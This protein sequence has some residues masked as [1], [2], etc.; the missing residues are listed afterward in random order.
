L[1]PRYLLVETFKLGDLLM[2]STVALAIRR[3]QPDAEML[4]LGPPGGSALPVWE[5][6]GV[7]VLE[8]A[9]PWQQ[10][11]WERAPLRTLQALG[12]LRGRLGS[13]VAGATGLDP[14]GD[15]RHRTLLTALGVRRVVGYRSSAP[16]SARWRGEL[17]GH[18]L[19]A[20][21][22]FLDQAVPAL[23]LRAPLTLAWPWR[24]RDERLVDPQL[25]LVAPEASNPLREWSSARWALL[26]QQCRRAGFRVVLVE[27]SGRAVTGEDREAFD[28]TWRG[29]IGALSDLVAR[30]AVVVAVD[31]LVGH[32]A[33]GQ[34]TPV[35]T[36]VGPQLP[37]RWRPVGPQVE[38]VMAEGFGCRPCGQR[39]CVRPGSRCM[40][41]IPVAEVW[42]AVQRCT[43]ALVP[44]HH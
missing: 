44:S 10:L 25:V 41:A 13:L 7:R 3:A 16:R 34:G 21:Q 39:L 8:A 32:L 37:E 33:S 9:L 2:A 31:S 15:V 36:L 4:V 40:D 11:G 23:G 29:S 42:M 24:M 18:V 20:R 38:I 19:E 17:D 30:A 22:R 1:P 27:Q 26:A 5:G 14:R 28:E 12:E 35:V 43:A 6:S